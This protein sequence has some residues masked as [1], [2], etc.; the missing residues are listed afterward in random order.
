MQERYRK[1]HIGGVIKMKKFLIANSWWLVSIITIALLISHTLSIAN[2]KIDNVTLVLLMILLI[3]PFISQIRKIKMGDFE[4]EIDPKEVQ[5]V[6]DDVDNKLSEADQEMI[7]EVQETINNIINLLDS[8][9]ILALAKLRIELEKTINKLHRLYTGD[10]DYKKNKTVALGKLVHELTLREVL[11]KD[12][13]NPLKEILYFCNRAVHGD[14]VKLNDARKIVDSGVSIYN[15]LI[16]ISKEYI[17]KPN[18]TIRISRAEVSKYINASYRVVT[19]IPYVENSIKNIRILDQQGLDE[20]L[21]G[22]SEYAEFIIEI[23]LI[24][25]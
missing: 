22:Y 4:A 24:D 23:S 5:K 15:F 14:E 16:A 6:K 13:S 9:R 20:L 25:L 19:V 11:P 17:T 3:S 18:E 2:F 21:D 1:Y 8:D 12:I 7:P 10:R